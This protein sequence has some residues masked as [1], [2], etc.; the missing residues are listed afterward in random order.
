MTWGMMVAARTPRITTTTMIS[1][2]V[3]APASVSVIRAVDDSQS[4]G[5]VFIKSIL[6][7]QRGSM[8]GSAHLKDWQQQRDDH[9][10]DQGA[11]AQDHRRCQQRNQSFD[12]RA[13]MS[14]FDFC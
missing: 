8:D 13:H 5:C 2:R 12:L 4:E 10:S 3:K 1:M 7:E 14:F 6:S 9:E 11:D